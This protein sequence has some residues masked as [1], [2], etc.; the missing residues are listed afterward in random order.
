M[1]KESTAPTEPLTP[2]GKPNNQHRPSHIQ[3]PEFGK[4]SPIGPQQKSNHLFNIPKP[5]QARAEHHRVPQRFNNQSDP[6]ARQNPPPA[7]PQG[8]RPSVPSGAVAATPASKRSEPWDPFKPVAPSAY[9]NHRGGFQP[10][11]VSIKRPEN[12]TWTTPR[13]PRPIFQSKPLPPKPSNSSKNLQSFIDLTRD[14]NDPV[15]RKPAAPAPSGFGAMDMN[16]YVDTAMANEN[17]KA[18]LE[19]AFED[20]EEKTQL[21]STNK[22]KKGSKKK[23]S[24]TKS[25]DVVVEDDKKEQAADDLDDLAAQ[26]SGVT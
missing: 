9:N 13:A 7:G 11:S 14:A 17:I 15:P 20:E 23:K 19:G 16:G 6:R 21:K 2:G 12:V 3:E 24:K 4:P 25:K 22:K 18:L 26:L 1:A 5:N 10:G 8:Y